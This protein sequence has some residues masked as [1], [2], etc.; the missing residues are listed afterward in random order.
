MKLRAFFVTVFIMAFCSYTFG[1]TKGYAVYTAEN[2]TITCYDDGKMNQKAGT[3]KKALL[4]SNGWGCGLDAFGDDVKDVV[5]V[6]KFDESFTSAK[7]L[8]LTRWFAD[9][10]ELKVISGLQYFDTSNVIIARSVFMGCH[11][12]ATIDLSSCSMPNLTNANS[13]FAYCGAKIIILFQSGNK[14]TSMNEMFAYSSDLVS[15][16]MNNLNTSQVTTM[17]KMFYEC[18]KLT[19][20]DLS[21]FDTGKVT[22][23]QNMFSFCESLTALNVNVFDTHN[24]TNMEGMFSHCNMLTEIGNSSNFNYISFD[25]GKVTVMNGM[26]VGCSSLENL[27]LSAFNTSNVTNMSNMFN[28]CKSLKSSHFDISSFDTSKVTDMSNMFERCE[29]LTS[30]N[31]SSFNTQSC[32]N[33]E[34]MFSM[35]GNLETIIVDDGW[36]MNQVTESTLMFQYCRVLK[37]SRG[38]AWDVIEEDGDYAHVDGGPSNPGYFTMLI[39]YNL[40][41]GGKQVNDVNKG[42]IIFGNGYALYIPEVKLL[43]LK[44]A[45]IDAGNNAGIKNGSDSSNGIDGL[46]IQIRG[47]CTIKSNTNPMVLYGNTTIKDWEETEN[48][49]V[50]EGANS[51][52]V[53]KTLTFKNK[54][55]RATIANGSL[56]SGPTTSSALVFDNGA[57]FGGLCS[58]KVVNNMSSITLGSGLEY[59]YL[60]DDYPIS[61]NSSEH[62]L[63]VGGS[64]L[65]D[66]LMIG[67]YY[68]L[69]IAG[70]HMSSAWELTPLLSDLMPVQISSEDVY[71]M[72][73]LTLTGTIPSYSNNSALRCTAPFLDIIVTDAFYF[74]TEEEGIPAFDYQGRGQ[75]TITGT[76][77]LVINSK[78]GPAVKADDD[79]SLEIKDVD[80][81]V[82]GK[83]GGF[84]DVKTLYFTN[85]EGTATCES[86]YVVSNVNYFFISRCYINNNVSFDSKNKR[87]AS[88]VL[89][90]GREKIVIS[91]DIDQVTSNKYQVTS[92]DWY[93]ID[94]RKLSGKPA[95][96]GV[97]IHNGKKAVMR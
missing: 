60:Y 19:S 74:V 34:R 97:Y 61:F 3:I 82:Q 16:V 66:I 54:K 45:T 59:V 76:G 21:S 48:K 31:L 26:F 78:N 23:M 68:P 30:L 86:G 20:I 50:M 47:N 25:T 69:W 73:K 56:F 39:K 94:G 55:T 15:I 11:K 17:V 90:I 72:K 22:T 6:V 7:F 49:L 63:Y 81:S 37:G 41:I 9:F 92:D 58:G 64:P 5:E 43:F 4:D 89:K 2:K 96:K 67:E 62:T 93:T 51:I 14:I 84:K 35:C 53:Y 70:Y 44:D 95:K 57:S 8:Y 77:T 83:T 29:A 65:K 87:I 12:L 46:Y 80:F 42:E 32:T 85:A 24:V 27:D 36:T 91:T 40:W 33:M 18:K 1:Q 10:K 88:N 79:S 13:M 38:T 71:S 75:C 52:N 28:G